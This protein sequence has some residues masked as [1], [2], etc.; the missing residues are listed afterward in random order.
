MWPNFPFQKTKTKTIKSNSTIF[1]KWRHTVLFTTSDV[2][3]LVSVPPRRTFGTGRYIPGNHDNPATGCLWRHDAAATEPHAKT[4]RVRFLMYSKCGFRTGL[5]PP[6]SAGTRTAAGSVINYWVRR[7]AAGPRDGRR[8]LINL[9][10]CDDQ[11]RREEE[12]RVKRNRWFVIDVQKGAEM[13]VASLIRL[14][15]KVFELSKKSISAPRDHR[16]PW[17]IS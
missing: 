16:G 4:G 11:Y 9:S 10:G 7:E 3:P 1:V 13:T 12:T 2:T 15:F 6:A 14:S 5:F 17:F 8:R